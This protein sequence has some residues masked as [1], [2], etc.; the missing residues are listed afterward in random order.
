MDSDYHVAGRSILEIEVFW[1]LPLG[2]ISTS[3]V[4]LI[5]VVYAYLMQVFPLVGYHA[6]PGFVFLALD[7]GLVYLLNIRDKIRYIYNLQRRLI[8]AK[9]PDKY[10]FLPEPYEISPS[11]IKLDFPDESKICFFNF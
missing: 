8:R 6:L 5:V 7:G 10:L 1:T 9:L 11:M 4:S 2:S 3:G